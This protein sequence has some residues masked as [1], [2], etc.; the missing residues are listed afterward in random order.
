M[1]TPPVHPT[2]NIARTAAHTPSSQLTAFNFLF[3]RALKEGGTYIIEDIETSYWTKGELY[4][5]HFSGGGLGRG[6][7]GENI[8]EIFKDVADQVNSEFFSHSSAVQSAFLDRQA[9]AAVDSIEFSHNV[10]ILKKKD[11][12][13][14]SEFLN[15]EYRMKDFVA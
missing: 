1:L 11:F 6:S 12:G 7:N 2:H 4:G 8:I 9:M 13:K 5:N 10:V 14:D 15:R 3:L